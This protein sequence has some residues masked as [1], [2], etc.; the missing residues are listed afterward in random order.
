M[1]RPGLKALLAAPRTVPGARLDAVVDEPSPMPVLPPPRPNEHLESV[2]L[3]AQQNPA[4]VAGILRG[5]VGT[6]AAPQ[7]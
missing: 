2:K 5:W 6:D 7:R 4:A 1:V 3:M